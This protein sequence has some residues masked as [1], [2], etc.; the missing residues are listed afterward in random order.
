LRNRH[1][2]RAATVAAT[3][4]AVLSLTAPALAAPKPSAPV[5]PKPAKV[6][7]FTAQG[8]VV[9]STPRTLR[10]IAR[11]ARVGTASLPANTVITVKRP[12]GK[13]RA[14]NGNLVGY[15]VTVT[16][17]AM[18]VGRSTTLTAGQETVEP[19]PA[20]VF[21]GAVSDVSGGRLT[22]ETVSAA[23]GDDFGAQRRTLTV[24]ISGAAS[25]VDGDEGAPVEGEFAV[26]LGER[27]EDTV[28]AATVDGW[29]EAPDVLA[30]AITDVSG[31]VV[32]LD[33]SWQDEEPGDEGE[34][35]RVRDDSPPAGEAPGDETPGGDV[36]GDDVPVDDTPGDEPPGDDEDPGDDSSLTVDLAPGGEAVP[37]ILDG[38]DTVDPSD[39]SAGERLLVLGSTEDDGTFTPVIAFAFDEDNQYPAGRHHRR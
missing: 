19:R 11:E 20:E 3:V 23:G 1:P 22:L 7:R 9:A 12:V 16:G 31:S 8:L 28:V 2:L 24:D 18:R 26:V 6:Q 27:E 34:R 25:T 35:L 39:L 14:G 15:A 5:K 30:G 32:T 17:S 37:V 33:D 38:G 36:P 4:A 29:T 10:V 13:G 21:V